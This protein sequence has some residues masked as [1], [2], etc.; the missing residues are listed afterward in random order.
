MKPLHSLWALLLALVF[1][2][3]QAQVERFVAG[4]HY[5]VVPDAPLLRELQPH[6][7]K[8]EVTEIF[9]YGCPHCYEFDPLLTAWVQKQGE[10][11]A[12]SRLPLNTDP[13]TK[14][15][16]RMFYTAQALG[17]GEKLH[18]AFFDTIHVQHNR[19]QNAAAVR[20]LFT[21]NGVSAAQFDGAFNGFAVDSQVRK[22]ASMML[23]LQVPS[24]PCMV[25]NGRY[26]VHID[27]AVPSH[28][29]MLE[30]VEF[31]LHKK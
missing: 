12:F 21:D 1:T 15:H 22:D 24:V 11:I 14:N 9:W 18:K 27:E 17:L 23:A 10:T 20:Q 26:L 13:V 6:G 19:L 8:P 3:T 4:T 28:Q 5:L 31:L 30:V 2:S 29:A 16:A 7:D 25:V